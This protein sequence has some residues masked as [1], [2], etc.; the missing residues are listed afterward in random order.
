MKAGG[1]V[2]GC[3]FLLSGAFL[4]TLPW[5]RPSFKLYAYGNS[6]K[7]DIKQGPTEVMCFVAERGENLSLSL[8]NRHE[9]V[10][11]ECGIKLPLR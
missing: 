7:Q 6:K 5:Q 2:G 11:D 10:C 4:A 9:N 1:S 8:I 3:F